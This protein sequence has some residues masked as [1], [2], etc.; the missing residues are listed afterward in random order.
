MPF[1]SATYE[2]KSAVVSEQQLSGPRHLTLG[3]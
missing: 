2:E 3:R 1:K